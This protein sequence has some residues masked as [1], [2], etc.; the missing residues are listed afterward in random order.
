[1]D[2]KREPAGRLPLKSNHHRSVAIF[3][4]VGDQLTR[5]EPK[6][7]ADDGGKI[8]FYAFNSDRTLGAH[9]RRHHCRDIAAKLF[10]GAL[11]RDV[12]NAVIGMKVAV[13]R[14]IIATR[15]AA[16]AWPRVVMRTPSVRA[17]L[18]AQPPSFLLP[19]NR[20]QHFHVF[21]VAEVA[22]QMFDP[23]AQIWRA[24]VTLANDGGTLSLLRRYDAGAPDALDVL[25]AAFDGRH[26]AL[27]QLAGRVWIEDGEVVCDPWSASADAFIVPDCDGAGESLTSTAPPR[28]ETLSAPADARTFLA[29]ALHAG[30][31]RRDEAFK[32]R[33]QK[34]ATTLATQG[35]FRRG[36]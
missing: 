27:R 21:E 3:E 8:K 2:R 36:R 24:A 12:F 15:S 25:G 4:G 6:R 14:P 34:L 31:R 17:E 1:M 26:G 10:Q 28:A 11:K 18:A 9:R 7:N 22:G 23:G 13:Y 30:A 35:L 29:G 33:G 20:V 5:N 32:R 19:R 16:S